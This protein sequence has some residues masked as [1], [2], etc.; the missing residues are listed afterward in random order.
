VV[1]SRV[2]RPSGSALLDE[3]AIAVLRRA[4]PLPGPPAEVS[5]ELFPLTLPIQFRIK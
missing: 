5:G 4:S 1:A 2:L 3:E